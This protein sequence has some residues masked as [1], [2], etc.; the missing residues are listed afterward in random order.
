MTTATQIDLDA[1]NRQ[2]AGAT[3]EHVVRWAAET[4]ST[5]LVMTSSFGAQSAVMLHLVTQVIPDIPVVFVDTGYLFPETYQFAEAL[6]RRLKLNLKVYQSPLSPARMEALMGRL[7]EEETKEALD[8][9]DQ[10]RKKEPMQRALRELGVTAWL[11]GLQR[12]QTEHR[13]KLRVVELQNG[14]PKIHPVLEWTSRD[15][16]QYLKRHDLPYHPLYEQ[17]YA[18]IGDVHSTRPIGEG[19]NERDGRFGGLKQECGLHLP[20]TPDENDSRGASNL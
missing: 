9:Y 10:I 16:Y 4:F 7:W 1:V 3:P 8:R 13:S 14:M 11:A 19:M 5:G 2:L 18:S 15:V 20:T 6:T 12:H 17:G